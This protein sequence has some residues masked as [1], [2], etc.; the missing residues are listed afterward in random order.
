MICIDIVV[1]F[2]QLSLLLNFLLSNNILLHNIIKVIWREKCSLNNNNLQYFG[3]IRK[4]KIFKVLLWL[5]DNNPLYKDIV[6]NFNPTNTWEKKFVSAG[7]LSRM[8]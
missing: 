5:K 4:I 8:L 6:I 7:I 1:F 2:Q 3:H